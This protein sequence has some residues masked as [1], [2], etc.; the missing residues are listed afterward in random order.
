MK[1]SS[2][3][4]VGLDV[5]KD[6]I[7]IAIAEL[8]RTGEV[9]HYG[10]VGGDLDS[11]AKVGGKIRSRRPGPI[12]FRRGYHGPFAFVSSHSPRS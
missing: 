11:L 3:A 10:A 2:T 4:F 6:S 1:N 8:G 9:R 7:D 12:A 5:H